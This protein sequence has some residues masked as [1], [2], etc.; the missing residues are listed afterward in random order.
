MSELL[1][2]LKDSLTSKTALQ[3]KQVQKYSLEADNY[4]RE[5]SLYIERLFSQ[6]DVLDKRIAAYDNKIKAANEQLR[7]KSELYDSGMIL[8]YELTEA[9]VTLKKLEAE[10]TQLV[11]DRDRVLYC[12]LNSVYR[13]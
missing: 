5:M 10:R 4:S 2:K 7:I 3:E 12:L 1:T 13:G 11:C 6:A 8:E 9:K